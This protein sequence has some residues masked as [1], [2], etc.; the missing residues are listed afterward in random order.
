MYNICIMKSLIVNEKFNSKKLNMFLMNNFNGLKLNTIYKALRKKDIRVN[1]KRINENIVVQT[2][3]V[4]DIYIPDNLLFSNISLS[5]STIY[6]DD[7]ILIIN[8]PNGIEVV[9]ETSL[10]SILQNKYKY[11]LPCHRLDRNTTGLIIFAKNPSTLNILEYKFKNHEI[12]KHY[13]CLVYGIP[14][15]DSQTLVAYLFKDSKKS[16]VY[17]SDF[18]K[19]GYQKIITSYTILNKFKNNACILDVN[20]HT[21]KTHQIRAH[22]AHIG[23]PIIGDGKYGINEINKK[24]HCKTQQLCSYKLR[25]NFTLETGLLDYLNGKEFKI[26]YM[27]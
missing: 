25:F 1:G 9:G 21:G 10:T 26:D 19:K 13:A 20:L 17:I 3:D 2:G 8:K 14:K 18:P 27:F 7:N 4:I 22:L 6:E 16:M 15:K 11:V 5:I 12:E 23:Y 24:F